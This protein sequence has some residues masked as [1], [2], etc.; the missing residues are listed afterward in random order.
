VSVISLGLRLMG[1]SD[2]APLAAAGNMAVI[3]PRT[4]R[5][6]PRDFDRHRYMARHLIENF[7]AKLKQFRAI[8]TRYDG[9][10]QNFLAPVHYCQCSLAQSTTGPSTGDVCTASRISRPP[11]LNDFEGIAAQSV[12][13]KAS[14]IFIMSKALSAYAR[15]F[16]PC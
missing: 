9:T 8:A 7:F 10:A 4:N 13:S 3:P 5:R 11:E 12:S 1:G 2:A 6:S 14:T 16:A 15:P